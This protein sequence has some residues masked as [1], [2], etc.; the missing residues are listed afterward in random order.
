MVQWDSASQLVAD[1]A[2]NA[3]IIS[4]AFPAILPGSLY[5][6]S[7]ANWGF[8]RVQN[9]NDTI[10]LI[11]AAGIIVDVKPSI[12]LYEEINRRSANVPIASYLAITSAQLGSTCVAFR[13]YV[14]FLTFETEANDPESF[15][16]SA[17]EATLNI[18]DQVR[19]EFQE[20]FGGADF[21]QEHLAYL[22]INL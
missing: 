17:V 21:T 7:Q 15:T 9:M 13:T 5:V 11:V 14:P 22:G 18:S 16:R 8:M 1:T 3:G 2:G 19:G 10:V 4:E 20:A 6:R 12:E